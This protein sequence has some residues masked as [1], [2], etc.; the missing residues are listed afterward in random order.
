MWQWT[1]VQQYNISFDTQE[2]KKS[3]KLKSRWGKH[4]YGNGEEKHFIS[5]TFV[6]LK[7][8]RFK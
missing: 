4:K 1:L 6:R 7:P 3:Y 8:Q 2:H 5:Y